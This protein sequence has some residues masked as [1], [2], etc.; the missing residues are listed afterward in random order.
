M[1]RHT[2]SVYQGMLLLESHFAV[3]FLT[4]LL[5]AGHH[6][7]E[8]LLDD[9]GP[10]RSEPLLSAPLHFMKLRMCFD[11]QACIALKHFQGKILGCSFMFIFSFGSPNSCY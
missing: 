11:I 9:R 3:S 4:F 8:E 6:P 2:G 10:Q 5:Y 1:R 7:S